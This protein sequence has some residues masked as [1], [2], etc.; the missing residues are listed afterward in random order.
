MNDDT[1]APKKS[2]HNYFYIALAAVLALIAVG[3]VAS[4]SG[5]DKALLRQQLDAFATSLHA[6]GERQGRDITLTYGEVDIKGSFSSK[7]GVVYDVK[8]TIKPMNTNGN[9][10]SSDDSLVIA[11]SMAQIY[12]KSVDLSALQIQL[13]QPVDFTSE[14][15]PAKKLLT[16]VANTPF[17]L[18]IAQTQDNKVDVLDLKHSFPTQIEFTYLRENQAEGTEDTTPTIVPVYKKLTMTLAEGGIVQSKFTVDGKGLGQSKVDLK[19]IQLQPELVP[20]GTVKIAQ[21]VADWSNIINEKDRRIALLKLHIGDITASADMLPY[22]PISLVIDAAFD[23]I[24]GQIPQDVAAL[25]APQ[26]LIKL[27]QFALSTKDAKLTANAD[28]TTNSGDILP[29]GTANVT[30]T[31]VPYVLKELRDNGLLNVQNEAMVVPILEL[32]T[33]QKIA[34]V[35]DAVIDVKRARGGAFSIGKTTFEELFAT[36]LKAAMMQSSIGVPAPEKPADDTK[37]TP[38]KGAMIL[39]DGARA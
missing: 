11:T 21:I 29:E 27:T 17:V 26:A 12:P 9:A 36:F 15:E 33:G 31:N 24:N 20:N 35:T 10:A 22:A 34:D 30:L 2:N 37:K 39:E 23:G 14:N 8:L 19:D 4:R 13:P 7:H 18:D 5:L 6:S 38:P 25:N 28:F 32:T 1:T 3:V 16:I